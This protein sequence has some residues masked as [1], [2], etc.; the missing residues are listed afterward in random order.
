[1][2][3]LYSCDDYNPCT[4]D[5]CDPATG[6]CL[7]FANVSMCDD[8]DGCTTDTC[9][10][11]SGLCRHQLILQCDDQNMCTI[12]T[13]AG[14]QC[15]NTPVNLSTVCGSS[16]ANNSCMGARCD[17]TTG[18]CVLNPVNCDD[19]NEC[20]TDTCVSLSPST[21]VC[22]H[23][24]GNVT[25]LCLLALNL[26][27]VVLPDDPCQRSYACDPQTGSC[28]F[29]QVDCD[30]HNPTTLD[31]CVAAP[32]G[33][34]T[35]WQCLHSMQVIQ[36]TDD[37]DDA[38]GV[39]ILVP[40]ACA[41]GAWT[42][43]VAAR[44][45]AGLCFK[46]FG[47]NPGSG[48]CT[49]VQKTCDDNKLCTVDTCD[50][51]TGLCAHVR[52]NCTSAN[53]CADGW[54]DDSTGS[55]ET[56]IVDCED[57]D[58]CTSDYCEAAPL[59]AAPARRRCI[60]RPIMC[61]LD[62]VVGE[63][64]V[65][66]TYTY[67][68]TG[69]QG[70][71]VGK[72]GHY[73]M[74]HIQWP[75]RQHARGTR[76]ASPFYTGNSS[77]RVHGPKCWSSVCNK[78]DG[79]C[80]ARA[81][82]CDD[83]NSCTVDTCNDSVGC[84]HTTI[85]CIKYLNDS[86]VD[87]CTRG[88][89]DPMKGGTCVYQSRNCDDFDP[90][91]ADMCDPVTGNCTHE[92][93]AACMTVRN[94]SCIVNETVVLALDSRNWRKLGYGVGWECRTVPVD[95]DDG[96]PCT[97]DTATPNSTNCCTHE[98][99]SC[100]VDATNHCVVLHCTGN[101]SEPCMAEPRDC[102]RF[103]HANGDDARL[104]VDSCMEYSC[105]PDIGC[106]TIAGQRRACPENPDMPCRE[107]R[108]VGV[109][110]DGT[111]TCSYD[112]R[113]AVC[114]DDNPCTIDYCA[115]SGNDRVGLAWA[116]QKKVGKRSAARYDYTQRQQLYGD[117]NP[118][119]ARVETLVESIESQH[120]RS[121]LEYVCRHTR[122]SCT[123]FSNDL[124][125]TGACSNHTGECVYQHRVCPTPPSPCLH[126]GVCVASTGMC[127]YA[128]RVLQ[129]D[130]Y[131]VAGLVPSA[132]S[133][134]SDISSSSSFVSSS[135]ISAEQSSDMPVKLSRRF[136]SP[137]PRRYQLI[138]DFFRYWDEEVAIDSSASN[139][140]HAASDDWWSSITT[141][142]NAY[143]PRRG[144]QTAYGDYFETQ[145][146]T[147]AE[148]GQQLGREVQIYAPAEHRRLRN[149]VILSV[150]LKPQYDSCV[151]V[152]CAAVSHNRSHHEAH[153]PHDEL[154]EPGPAL[155]FERLPAGTPCI[156][157]DMRQEYARL[158]KQLPDTAPACGRVH[159][160]TTSGV[161]VYV[162]VRA[163][164]L[165]NLLRLS[166]CSGTWPLPYGGVIPADMLNGSQVYSIENIL[167]QACGKMVMRRKYA[168]ARKTT[169]HGRVQPSELQD[170]AF[171][172]GEAGR[173]VHSLV[174][175]SSEVGIVVMMLL[176]CTLLICG[177]AAGIIIFR[178]HKEKKV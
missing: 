106:V 174:P 144:E 129:V 17:T 31:M 66:G 28:M 166:E 150:E 163:C 68:I 98:R 117:D 84:V 15:V 108:C 33:S 120:A 103:G 36:V 119:E 161:C 158:H 59:W 169:Q 85:P 14:G 5:S 18:G 79:M 114:D 165:P 83:G 96:D 170:N 149:A 32:N 132:E 128:P 19:A 109:A 1:M 133:S 24:Y 87:Q 50:P 126:E 74:V 154:P 62:A 147:D 140:E 121:T 58:Y 92:Y 35:S 63:I 90:T 44:E 2:H 55:C 20:T 164:S 13:C 99:Y 159:A 136:Q 177:L 72:Q 67:N 130:D 81:L 135:L 76:S 34:A 52:K 167:H 122:V 113:S 141:R 118:N 97:I 16:I 43:A 27:L 146:G 160:C 57:G 23:T 26:S 173:A 94:N 42:G 115:R 48:N 11:W 162:G 112:T 46:H 61:T 171:Y 134:S 56:R 10:T 111:L 3:R 131:Y 172:S 60:H 91:T 45:A 176:A 71:S 104:A 102:G 101:V 86:A 53:P 80:Y 49:V 142:V 9:D 21:H 137:Q 73:S 151:R 93:E 156:S 82:D 125:V 124:C 47:V 22:T 77:G 148:G 107:G 75:G 168:D 12:D 70:R 4:Q 6:Y 178:K 175:S 143:W 105:V 7:H 30:D 152:S 51:L 95:C 110:R 69:E 38:S 153:R 123:E 157:E 8:G 138:S 100:G 155:V 29:N 89:C 116:A 40:I 41:S 127:E 78:G 54:C 145:F 88:E 39:K 65:D 37:G 64:L 139:I 25:A